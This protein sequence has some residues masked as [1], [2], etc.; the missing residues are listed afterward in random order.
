MT[1]ECRLCKLGHRIGAVIKKGKR[2]DL[3][4]MIE[5]LHG[6]Y[7]CA[8]LDENVA[9]AV[10]EGSWPNADE[11]IAGARA[12]RPAAAEAQSAID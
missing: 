9:S 4:A 3:I 5:E 11:I 2:A 8:L 7:L 10:I 12:N 6:N 1:C